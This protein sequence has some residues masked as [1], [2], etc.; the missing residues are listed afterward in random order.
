MP[1]RFTGIVLGVLCLVGCASALGLD[2]FRDP[3]PSAG[4][5][6]SAGA[7]GTSDGGEGGMMVT[8][9]GCGEE[10]TPSVCVEEPI[11]GFSGPVVLSA[12]GG[13]CGATWS[14]AAG[15]GAL[16]WSAE[17]AQ[18][19]CK[20]EAVGGSC[21]GMDLT[22]FSD[23]GCV[24]QQ[25]TTSHSEIRCNNTSGSNAF[26]SARGAV[27]FT[28][29]SCNP[30]ETPPVLPDVTFDEHALC[31]LPE[32][33][34]KSDCAAGEVCVPL[35]DPE[36]MQ[37]V[38]VVATEDVTTCPAAFS[39]RFDLAFGSTFDDRRGCTAC[40]CPTSADPTCTG[41]VEYA[42]DGAC[43]STYALIGS[44]GACVTP[45]G[46][47]TFGFIEVIVSQIAS[48][49]CSPTAGSGEPTGTVAPFESYT[50]CCTP[51][52]AN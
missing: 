7:G 34:P 16:S 44:D 27:R 35:P 4:G 32:P 12:P 26:G 2:E 13:G 9:P 19:D 29:G 20:C 3:E 15:D 21:D 48:P 50:L 23:A 28:P 1:G 30:Q 39:Q 8:L 22:F 42:T 24:S 11:V 14:A 5:G 46:P 45:S 49:V 51:L 41:S 25:S 6:G 17:P 40:A 10:A 52:I 47:D 18:C 31:E 37:R 38:C 36:L 43:T 33:P